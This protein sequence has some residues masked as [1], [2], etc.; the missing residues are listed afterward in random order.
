LVDAPNGFEALLGDGG[1]V[2]RGN[3]GRRDLTI[4]FVR[5]VH[6]EALWERLARNPNVDDVWLVWAKKVSPSYAGITQALVRGAGIARGFVDFKV[7]AVDDTW[8]GLRFKRRR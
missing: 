4:V 2:R 7:C 1:V 3:G 8:S 5:D 6:V